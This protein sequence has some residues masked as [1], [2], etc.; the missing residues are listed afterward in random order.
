MLFQLGN[1]SFIRGNN[2]RFGDFN[3]LILLGDIRI[4]QIV[5]N[6]N[7]TISPMATRLWLSWRASQHAIP[8]A[9][10]AAPAIRA[11]AVPA[12]ASSGDPSRRRTSRE[13][14]NINANPAPTSTVAFT[15][16]R[17]FNCASQRTPTRNPMTWIV[18]R[19]VI[20]QSAL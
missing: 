14:N 7:A 6:N 16:S 5:E 18:V 11:M 13:G 10:K 3:Q 12:G 8:I 15:M 20:K 9:S 4:V 1:H 17:V 2:D 19:L